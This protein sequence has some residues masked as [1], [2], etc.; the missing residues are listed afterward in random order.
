[1]NNKDLFNAIQRLK[2]DI[3]EL[4][5]ELSNYEKLIDEAR[6][7]KYEILGEYNRYLSIYTIQ[8]INLLLKSILTLGVY[9]LSKKGLETRQY[10]DELEEEMDKSY[11]TYENIDGCL[12]SYR[13]KQI[14]ITSKIKLLQKVYNCYEDSYSKLNE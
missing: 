10:I 2:I 12:N 7:E 11:D 14:D 8:K 5:N 3:N 4:N 9:Y 1:M 13:N 6:N